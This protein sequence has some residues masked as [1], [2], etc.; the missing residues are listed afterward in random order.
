MKKEGRQSPW[1]W[2]PTLY[3]AEGL[4]YIAVMS[5]AVIMF[6]RFGMSNTDIAFYTS[7]LYLPWTI[8][9]FWSPFVDIIKTKRWWIITTQLLIGAGFG[10][11]A[12]SLP[13]SHWFQI[14]MAFFWILAFSSATHDISADG[15]YMIGL[16]DRQQAFFVGI[17]NT[18]YRLA[19]ITGQGLL[20]I[21]A[22]YLEKITP[23]Q[24][25]GNIKHIPFAWCMTFLLMGL[26]FIFIS[27]YH[28]K[29]LP[30]P[31]AE[32]NDKKKSSK[33]IFAEFIDT[34]K[35]FF[36]K[37]NSAIAILFLFF[38]RISESQLVKISSPFLL[39]SSKK[40]GL[41][42]STSTV[43]TVYGIVGV[44]ALIAGGITGGILISKGGLKK[45]ILP[46]ALLLNIPN[47][48]YILFSY[49][50]TPNLIF[51]NC[52]IAIEQFGYGFGFTAYTMYMI[53]FAKGPYKT[54]HYAFC[55]AIMAFGMMLPGMVAGKIADSLGYRQFFIYVM[56][57]TII[58]L[59]VSYAAKK[60]LK[61]KTY[62]NKNG[63]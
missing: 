4:P 33:E 2:I 55:T 41:E 57:T 18:F 62:E 28:S 7:S 37:K 23:P 59:A 20:V 48:I 10:G 17:R 9:F 53:E 31:K 54:A 43:G 61:E 3:F 58:S 12:L 63:N 32:H 46:M 34:I 40:G 45:W 25:F 24:L 35:T 51:I 19:M 14:S 30:K 52:G 21:F 11:I 26:F 49:M 60:T 29:A 36:S 1:T 5:V 39:D 44:I 13:T 38:Y 42:L 56:W 15:F 8:K 6:K 16:D 50:Q 22:G 47:L 27:L